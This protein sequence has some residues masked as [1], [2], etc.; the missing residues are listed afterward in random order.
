MKFIDK[1][2]DP[3][4]E[5]LYQN[6]LPK[7]MPDRRMK[8]SYKEMINSGEMPHPDRIGLEWYYII[9]EKLTGKSRIKKVL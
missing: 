6:S 9:R 4:V 1:L 3:I 8:K 5:Y 2:I 7:E